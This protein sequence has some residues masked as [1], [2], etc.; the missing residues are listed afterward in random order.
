MS[1]TSIL[2]ALSLFSCKD[3]GGDLGVPLDTDTGS[4]TSIDAD[5][6][7]FSAEED[8]NDN[9]PGIYPGAVEICDGNDNNCNDEIDESVTTTYYQDSDNDGFGD[10]SV[11]LQACEKPSGYV[12]V[13]GDCDDGEASANPGTAEICDYIDNNCDGDI[14]E[15]TTSTYYADADLDGF[16]DAAA[17]LDECRQPKG[18]VTNDQDCDD[19]NAYAWPGNAESCDEADNDCDTFVDEGVTTTF[20]ADLDADNYGD[21]ALSSEACAQP[22]G[23][24]DRPS[25]C[26]GK[27]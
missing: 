22:T 15:G 8:C 17:S 23:Y 14:D 27:N 19:T 16:G 1:A 26:C 2:L 20:Y 7:G 5:G 4:A 9:D 18:Y 10:D 25:R 13:G 11:N 6:D 12:P 3:D 24:A 21:D